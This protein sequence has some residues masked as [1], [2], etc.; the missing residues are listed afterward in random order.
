MALCSAAADAQEGFVVIVLVPV[1]GGHPGESSLGVAT[2][3]AGGGGHH[4]PE[5]QAVLEERSDDLQKLHG[6]VP[7]EQLWATQNNTIKLS[8]MKNRPQKQ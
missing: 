6:A 4:L 7:L 8:K 2:Y 3:Q 1:K 5:G